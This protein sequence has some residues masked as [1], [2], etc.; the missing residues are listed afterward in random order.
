MFGYISRRLLQSVLVLFGVT[1]ICFVMFQY[2]GD[3]VL[4]LAGMDATKAQLAEEKA[5]IAA[6]PR[7]SV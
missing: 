7:Q 6:L 3:P 4:A 5:R 2:M 1:V